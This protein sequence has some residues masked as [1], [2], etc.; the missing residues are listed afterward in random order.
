MNRIIDYNRD[1]SGKV[2]DIYRVIMILYDYLNRKELNERID[3]IKE[4]FIKSIDLF[5][6]YYDE[7]GTIFNRL[8]G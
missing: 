5:I 2:V 1:V 3:F 8:V 4:Y 7:Y 6:K